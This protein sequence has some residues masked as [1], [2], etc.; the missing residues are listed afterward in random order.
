MHEALTQHGAMLARKFRHA[1]ARPDHRIEGVAVVR[2]G[3]LRSGGGGDVALNRATGG[4]DLFG[5]SLGGGNLGLTLDQGLGLVE[6]G[7][8]LVVTRLQFSGARLVG[9]A[10]DLFK[11]FAGLG[12]QT[13][14]LVVQFS[15]GHCILLGCVGFAKAKRP[16]GWLGLDAFP[17]GG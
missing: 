10:L 6:L 12:D 1:A 16:A 8:D 14:T 4:T 3:V 13:A 5:A 2:R 15:V 9:V 7:H 17:K 11:G